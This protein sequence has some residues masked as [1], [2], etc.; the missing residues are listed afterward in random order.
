MVPVVGHGD[1]FGEPLGLVVNTPRADGVHMA[2]VVLGLGMDLGI[3]VDLRG[4]GQEEPGAVGLR[5]AQ[6]VVGSEAPHLQRLDGKFQVV[7]RAGRG[8]EV[9]NPI[10]L[11]RQEKGVEMS[12]SMKKNSWRPSRCSRFRQLPVMKLST[13]TTPWPRSQETI[14]QMGAQKAGGP[15]DEDAHTGFLGPF[16][17][18]SDRPSRPT[19]WYSNPSSLIL[20]GRYRF[21]PIEHHRASKPP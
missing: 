6:G 17:V 19:E 5:Q 18:W 11:F 10:D 16:F 8:G 21:L 12:C 14:H 13:P 7:H 15:G 3:P 9:E 4:G 2:P 20:S 1:G